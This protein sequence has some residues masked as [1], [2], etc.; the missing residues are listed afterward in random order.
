[1]HEGKFGGVLHGP[2]VQGDPGASGPLGPRGP[3]GLQDHKT[4][5][6]RLVKLAKESLLVLELWGKENQE[7]Q[8]EQVVV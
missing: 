1:M 2:A 7:L 5:L 3:H 4:C 8:W 6:D